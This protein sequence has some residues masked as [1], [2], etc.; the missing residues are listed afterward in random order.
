M[1]PK[2]KN[3]RQPRRIA[4][5]PYNFVPLP[6]KVVTVEDVPSQD[7]YSGYTGCVECLLTTESPLYTR[8]GMNPE[9][10]KAWGD[11][12]FHE[13]P[14]GV[15]NE[16]AQ[17]FSVEDVRRPIIPASSLRGMVRTLVEIAGYGKVK[18]VTNELLVFRSVGESYYREYL[19]QE[20]ARNQY[21]PLMQAGY[22]EK[23]GPNWYIRPAQ[24]IGGTT[25][26]RIHH[27]DIPDGLTQWHD[28]Q[29]A[30]SIW[31]KLGKY[32]YQDVRGFIKVKYTPVLEARASA[33]P[34][35]QEAVLA[36]SG[37]MDKKRREAVVFPSVKDD[38]K[39]ILVDEDMVQAYREQI[40]QEQQA[41]LGPDGALNPHQ[42]VFYLMKGNE[43]VFF[44]HVMLFRLPYE[45][46]P[47]SL[48]PERLKSNS[49]IDL[50]EAIFGYVPEG[51]D[52]Q[53][54]ACAGRVFFANACPEPG[55]SNFW[56]SESPVLPKI[57]SGPKP[58]AFQHYLT[59]QEPDEVDTGQRDKRGNPKI[60]L[61]LD[62]YNSPPPHETTIRGH[63]LYWHRG[64][65]S[66]TDIQESDQEALAKHP[67]QYTRIK[68]VRSKVTFRFTIHFE[69]LRDFELGALLWALTLPGEPG[70]EYRHKLGMGKPLGMGSV[71][72]QPA[73]RLSSR[74]GKTGRYGR[75][76]NKNEDGQ[77]L[78][79][80]HV[81][82]ARNDGQRFIQVFND[83]VLSHMDQEERGHASS[84]KDVPRIQML[85]KMLEWPGPERA[86]TE[87]MVLERFR[88][89]P[90]LPDPL[91]VLAG[92]PAR[93]TAPR[94]RPRAEAPPTRGI[95]TGTVK[96][97]NDQKGYGF[98][99]QDDGPDVF[100]HFSDIAGSGHRTLKEG[101]RVTF[102]V[103][104][105][106]KGPKAQNV[107]L[108]Q[109]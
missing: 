69:N 71:H 99:A 66:L 1:N 22:L 50:A 88:H 9:V 68:P 73:L 83:Y 49:V 16:R 17:F 98:I 41:L 62:H 103:V 38:S 96:W 80:W 72:L 90:V 93:D 97:F 23:E 67:K 46:T 87:Y 82:E 51:K 31:V 6:E 8:A 108:L 70:K 2:H 18:W 32:E 106:E 58:T 102:T 4:H 74:E 14:E 28:C 101:Q 3:P 47:F 15:K 59:Q 34:G 56:L 75:L 5:A 40:S 78:P 86:K 26:A 104:Q 25:F 48:L 29:N 53:R 84:L 20:D 45:H 19:M 79:E 42:P 100:V 7:V 89:R 43:L 109:E 12:S 91:A 54:Q 61:R 63:K 65:V 55:Q 85:L 77:L 44:G 27:D 35:F 39:R 36:Y 76:F 60:E 52:D 30:Y 57:L 95:E 105:G 13:L 37:P 94:P 33:T 11:K 64:N 24:S 107:C 10:F 21:T 92:R 81:A